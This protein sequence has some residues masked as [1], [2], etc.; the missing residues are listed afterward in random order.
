MGAPALDLFQT[1]SQQYCENSCNK[2]GTHSRELGFGTR[3]NVKRTYMVV[4]WAL[5]P[6]EQPYDPP[7]EP[8]LLSMTVGMVA[9]LDARA[10][11]MFT[12]DTLLSAH[13]GIHLNTITFAE[14]DALF[15][16]IRI[17]WTFVDNTLP[18]FCP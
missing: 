1:Q 16:I 7:A 12:C 14:E 8:S 2:G 6:I 10:P 13:G 9:T 18:V 15:G 11:V 17:I 3:R 5:K 4:N